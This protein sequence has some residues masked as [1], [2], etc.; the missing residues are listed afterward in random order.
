MTKS[1]STFSHFVDIVK[2]LRDPKGGCPW[3]LEQTHQTLRPYLIEE[4]YEVL[5]AI[6]KG[7]DAELCAELGDLLLQIVLHAQLADEHGKFSINDVVS[8]ITEKMIR[9][10]PHIFGDVK[11]QS[12]QEV[13]HNWEAIKQTERQGN[14][15]SKVSFLTGVPIS[16]PA[17]LRAQRLG[18]KAAKANFDWKSVAEVWKKVEEEM[19]ELQREL[20]IFLSPEKDA[21]ESHS[22]TDPAVVLT[23]EQ[24]AC[25]EHELGDVLFSL[26]Q[27]SR[28]LGLSAEESLRACCK[29]F[30]ARFQE[31]EREADGTLRE[32][33]EDELEELW[34]KAK[35]KLEKS[36]K[37][38]GGQ[39]TK[40]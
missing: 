2:A 32:L 23:Q 9:R 13:L 7:D 40:G 36:L 5:E 38:E 14:D 33:S 21:P 25:L 34:Q 29:R 27:L 17:L 3:D 4:A 18:E 6:E 26:C 37:K 28:F 22:S 39:E 1:P 8:G 15:G 35:R 20:N 16:L 19:T 24:R 10:H 30:E 12:S 11:V 31:M